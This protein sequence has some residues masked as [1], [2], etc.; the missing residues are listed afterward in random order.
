MNKFILCLL[1]LFTTLLPFQSQAFIHVARDG[2]TLEQLS[3][4]YYGTRDKSM[5]IRA[6]NGFMH[7]DDG[8]LLQGE[9]VEVPEVGYHMVQDNQNWYTLANSYLGSSK[10]AIFLAELN[11]SSVDIAPPSGKIV[12]IPYQ[13]LYIFAPDET[14]KS[15]AKMFL[16][17]KYDAQWLKNY[18]LKIRKKY[19]RG[20]AILIPLIDVEYTDDAKKKILKLN[21]TPISLDDKKKQIEAAKQITNL[22]VDYDNGEYLKIISEGQ[23]LLSSFQ[24]TNPQKIG[25]YKYL[26]FS[27]VAFDKNSM[28]K[29]MFINALKLQPSM[30]LSPI[31]VSP[32]ILQVFME[33]E[34]SLT[35]KAE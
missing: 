26:G 8:S 9:R 34:N 32:K 16:G 22:R 29:A 21:E 3:V 28:A 19:G 2:E 1:I 20:D 11:G 5:V 15:V 24:L 14:L 18:N 23:K 13:L 27:Y 17:K 31:T 35:K 10:R 30:E 33:A 7:P 6:A 25:I 4:Y 12:K